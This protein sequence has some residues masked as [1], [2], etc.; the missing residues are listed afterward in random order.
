MYGHCPFL[1]MW[2]RARDAV[3]GVYDKTTFADL[4]A[5]EAAT[6]QCRN[7]DFSI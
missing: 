5:E 7:A 2:E 6:A 3:E 4:L 1:H